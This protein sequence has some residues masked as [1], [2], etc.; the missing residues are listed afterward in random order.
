MVKFWT[1]ICIFF[2]VKKFRFATSEINITDLSPRQTVADE[3]YKLG[4]EVIVLKTGSDWE[5]G[6]VE[7]YLA[8]FT[9]PKHGKP[10]ILKSRSSQSAAKMQ[11]QNMLAKIS[12]KV[13]ADGN[14]ESVDK[15]R[16]LSHV[17]KGNPRKSKLEIK[18][19]FNSEQNMTPKTP[20]KSCVKSS[21]NF[22]A[23]GNQVK[24]NVSWKKVEFDKA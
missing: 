2:V 20:R 18:N 8:K 24:R 1:I 9:T 6:D 4:N 19:T 7:N 17:P 13:K 15:H 5:T 22:D 11:A 23:E 16:R 3:N 12:S 21:E 14:S 10:P